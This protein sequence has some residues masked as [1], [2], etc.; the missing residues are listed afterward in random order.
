MFQARRA[1]KTQGWCKN[2]ISFEEA[3]SFAILPSLAKG[4]IFTL[5]AFCSEV[6]LTSVWHSTH[7][8][9]AV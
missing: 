2:C 6:L 3:S 1:G 9:I 7:I 8:R 4:I 5:V